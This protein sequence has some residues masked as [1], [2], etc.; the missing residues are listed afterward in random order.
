MDY[1]VQA[2]ASGGNGSLATPYAL[3]SEALA[4]AASTTGPHNVFMSAGSYEDTVYASDTDLQG[5]K[6]YGVVDF[7]IVNA[8]LNNPYQVAEIG[9]VVHGS[10]TTFAFRN[11]VTGAGIYMQGVTLQNTGSQIALYN[12]GGVFTGEDMAIIDCSGVLINSSGGTLTFNRSKICG[13]D[14]LPA[15]T[16]EGSTAATFNYCALINT[17]GK[18]FGKN[19]IRTRDT[20]NAILNNC[21]VGGSI[22]GSCLFN[23]GTDDIV[24][25]NSIILANSEEQ[26]GF[27]TVVNSGDGSVVLNSCISMRDPSLNHLLYSGTVTENNV[28]NNR[29]PG[30]TRHMK[31]GYLLFSIDDL[32]APERL[33]YVKSIESQV[34]APRGLRA[35]WFVDAYSVVGNEAELATI[36]ERGTIEIGAHSYS[37]S[38]LTSSGTIITVSKA[39]TD[40]TVDRIAD[41]I[42]V[43]SDVLSGFRSMKITDIR[44]ALLAFSGVSVTAVGLNGFS[45]RVLGESFAD[46]TA[47]GSLNIQALLDTTAQ[48]GFYWV[49]MTYAK[50]IIEAATGVSCNSF[51][52]P[53]GTVNENVRV[54]LK[55]AGFTGA[56]HGVSN[57][58]QNLSDIDLFDLG[59]MQ[60]NTYFG[61]TDEEFTTNFYALCEAFAQYGKVASILSHST[62]EGTVDQWNFILDLVQEYS[63]IEILAQEDFSSLVATDPAWSTS[64]SGRTYQRTWT[65]QSDY[66]LLSDSLGYGSGAS[67]AGLHDQATVVEDF[68][69]DLVHFLPPNIG[70]VDGRTSKT[71]TET[72]TPTGYELRGTE[73]EPATITL[74][75]HNCDLSGLTEDEY[76]TL[77]V[78]TGDPIPIAQGNNQTLKT[79]GGG[80]GSFGFGF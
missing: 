72:Y 17:A 39:A 42:T 61:T 30:F 62:A 25:N 52:T 9:E 54:A 4:A 69:Q 34:L 47:S 48:T 41:T 46:G 10:A 51:A 68:N 76:V 38:T 73:D 26:G 5:C 21:I 18:A 78:K 7:T 19:G 65:D 11:L 74:N 14:E 40:I 44:T 70:P 59:F 2:G 64:D 6:I 77:K 56:R 36:A 53:G 67:V 35:T 49:E 57:S 28:I 58:S 75:G 22:N 13:S 31:T 29:K 33:N 71:L 80:G 15:V 32:Y 1:Y 8:V 24:C 43:G 45:D 3:L 63:D 66:S 16:L 23:S 20:A 79:S 55:N 60:F 50:Q 37:H 27:N 12:Q